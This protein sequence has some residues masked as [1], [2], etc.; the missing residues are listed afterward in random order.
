LPIKTVRL[1]QVRNPLY[2]C[3]KNYDDAHL[4]Q[5]LPVALALLLRRASLMSVSKATRH[6]VSS[7][8]ARPSSRRNRR[9]S[10]SRPVAPVRPAQLALWRDD[11]EQYCRGGSAGGQ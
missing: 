1:I 11:D 10:K 8:H 4:R 3:F 5:V 6:F 2:A 9:C 7:T